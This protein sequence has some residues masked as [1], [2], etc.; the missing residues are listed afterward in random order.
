[1]RLPERIASTFVLQCKGCKQ[2]RQGTDEYPLLQPDAGMPELIDGETVYP[3]TPDKLES[4]LP[5]WLDAGAWIV[6]GCCGT[7][8][9]HY[10][11]IAAVLAARRDH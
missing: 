5:K 2:I 8:I 3:K 11:R 9:E 6:G 10:R 7:T 4:V 1:V